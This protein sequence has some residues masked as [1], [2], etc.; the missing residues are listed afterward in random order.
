MVSV[1]EGELIDPC[2]VCGRRV[3]ANS[4]LCTKCG[5]WVRGRCA[6]IKRVTVRLAMLFVCLRCREKMEG[7]V[8]FIKKLCNVVETVNVFCYLGDKTK[9]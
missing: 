8:D 1:L 7:M 2:G 9:F 3:M 5:N 4:V 6:E